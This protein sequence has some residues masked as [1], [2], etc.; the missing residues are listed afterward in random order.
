MRS[1][2]GILGGRGK[3]IAPQPEPV[4][5]SAL[6]RWG[7]RQGR[8][9]NALADSI[10]LPRHTGLLLAAALMVSA[11]SY[12]AFAGGHLD[13]LTNS[14]SRNANLFGKK[15]GLGIETILITGAEETSQSRIIEALG[16]GDGGSLLTFGAYAARER[17]QALPWIKSAAVR[18]L[19][20]G[21]IQVQVKE[22]QAFALWQRRGE[23]VM[24]D[25]SGKEIERFSDER[26]AGLPLVVGKGA[27]KRAA[28][29]L[30]MVA[31]HSVVATRFR[32]AVLVANR[33][34]N[35]H[36]DNGMDLRLPENDPEMALD[37]VA[38][39][40]AQ[41]QLLSR[42]ITTVDLRLPDRLIVRLSDEAAFQRKATLRDGPKAAKPETD[43]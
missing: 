3:K 28:V 19:Y 5:P 6:G 41:R 14:I 1:L 43:T 24:I 17:L 10:A 8:R 42:D 29:L 13:P 37:R 23:I 25:R 38:R 2:S 36:L 33:R 20:P 16:I 7:A 18:K 32:A 12:G 11:V 22:R 15:A 40:D 21:T 27:N 30:E 4:A 34:W 39:L 9:I 31:A 35:V 26:F